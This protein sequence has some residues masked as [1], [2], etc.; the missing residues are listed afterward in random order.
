VLAAPVDVRR[1]GAV[2]AR[3]LLTVATILAPI[4]LLAC[5]P[6]AF[7]MFM[8]T[9]RADQLGSIDNPLLRL[10]AVIAVTL[11]ATTTVAWRFAYRHRWHAQTWWSS[12]SI[13]TSALVL[14]TIV[15]E[16]ASAH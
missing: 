1:S 5:G 15:Y 2:R 7:G 6:L 14:G 4:A 10:L 3:R 16:V 8:T 13:A 9:N 11:V 12:A